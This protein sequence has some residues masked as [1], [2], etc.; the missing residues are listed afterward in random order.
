MEQQSEKNDDEVADGKEEEH[1]EGDGKVEEEEDDQKEEDG[2][3]DKGG[4]AGG[5]KV[6]RVI[7]EDPK[8]TGKPSSLPKYFFGHQNAVERFP[9]RA[10]RI[11]ARSPSTATW[12]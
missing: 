2:E 10:Q 1:D 6:V 9:F 3:G 4:D 8:D 12:R 11:P 7:K 5:N